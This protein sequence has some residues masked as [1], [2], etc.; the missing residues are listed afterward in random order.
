MIR[1]VF[2]LALV[3]AAC[4]HGGNVPLD[5]PYCISDTHVQPCADGS[6]RDGE[7]CALCDDDNLTLSCQVDTGRDYL[8]AVCVADCA[9]CGDASLAKSGSPKSSW[10]AEPGVHLCSPARWRLGQ[11]CATCDSDDLTLATQA[12]TIDKFCNPI[13]CVRTCDGCALEPAGGATPL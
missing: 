9:T 3:L 6:K 12:C 8:Y 5:A 1:I 4:S 13:V 2:A 7:P 11:W 10:Y